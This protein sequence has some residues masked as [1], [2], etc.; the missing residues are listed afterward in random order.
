M[1]PHSQRLVRAVGLVLTVSLGVRLA[2][3]LIAPLLP[4]LVVLAFV[5]GLL[6]WM[7]GRR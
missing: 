4:A 3:W 6:L 5:G 7:I 2:A 1:I